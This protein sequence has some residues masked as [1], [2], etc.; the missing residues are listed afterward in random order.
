M[1]ELCQNILL[2][3]TLKLCTKQSLVSDFT[4]VYYVWAAIRQSPKANELCLTNAFLHVI[5]AIE[6]LV[7]LTS[8]P[9]H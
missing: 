8:F 5:L 1:I 7:G 4:T 2:S 3:S 9:L 6:F